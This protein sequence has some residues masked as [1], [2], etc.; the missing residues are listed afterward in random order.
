MDDWVSVTVIAP[1]ADMSEVFAKALLIAGSQ[2][3][4]MVAHNAP[5]I[6]YLAVD[7]EGKIWGTLES[8]EFVNE[9]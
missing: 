7:R 3:A 9:Y 1:H 2:E 6:A 4:E 8:L 5:E